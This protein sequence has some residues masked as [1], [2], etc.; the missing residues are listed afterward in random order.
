MK[1]FRKMRLV[2]KYKVELSNEPDDTGKYILFHIT[3]TLRGCNYQRIYKGSYKEC[4]KEKKRL[5]KERKES[6]KKGIL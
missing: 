4:H 3:E 2:D 6:I 5:E 1:L